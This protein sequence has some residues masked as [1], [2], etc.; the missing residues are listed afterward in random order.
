MFAVAVPNRVTVGGDFSQADLVVD[1]LA[2]VTL[3][4]LGL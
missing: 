1:T 4:D 3:S 2:D